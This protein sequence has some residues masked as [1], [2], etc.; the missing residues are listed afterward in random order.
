MSFRIRDR[1]PVFL[2]RS[3]RT[4]QSCGTD[5]ALDGFALGVL[6]RSPGAVGLHGFDLGIG[7]KHKGQIE[8]GD[9]LIVGVDAVSAHADDDGICLGNW[10]DSVAEPARFL[11]STRG[12]VFG[13]KP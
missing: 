8:L 4:D 1:N 9:K 3:I 7:K 10:F 13:I 11:G 6:P 5:R 2:D 12:V